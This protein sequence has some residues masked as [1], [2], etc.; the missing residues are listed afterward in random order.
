MR[1]EARDIFINGKNIADVCR[2]TIQENSD[3]F[4]Q[5]K[6]TPAQE[7]IADRIL[8]EIRSRLR[9]LD[10]VGLQYLTLDRLSS[11]L[12]GG[13]AQRIQLGT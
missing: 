9:F 7:E 6:L 10:D 2:M 5:L 3:F 12:S 11:T 8:F 13:D 4:S 1:Q